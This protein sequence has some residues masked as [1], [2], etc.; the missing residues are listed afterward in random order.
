MSPSDLKQ[1]ATL[2]WIDPDRSAASTLILFA[3]SLIVSSPAE[4]SALRF[5]FAAI[6]RKADE[7]DPFQWNTGRGYRIK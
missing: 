2:P 6:T 1:L 4:M 3:W 7:V 5:L